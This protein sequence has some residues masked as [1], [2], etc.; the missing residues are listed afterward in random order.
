M[1]SWEYAYLYYVRVFQPGNSTV[2]FVLEDT[3]GLRIIGKFRR[4]IDALNAVGA[5]GWIAQLP[6]WSGGHA[7]TIASA[8]LVQKNEGHKSVCEFV[9]GLRRQ[10]PT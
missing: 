7:E 3:A 2:S 9:Y 8:Q 6:P 10:A 5:E 1:N 4:S